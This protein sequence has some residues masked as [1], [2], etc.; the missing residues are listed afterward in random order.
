M[1]ARV[2]TKAIKIAEKIVSENGNFL[3][4]FLLDDGR[5]ILFW[6]T[7]A[8]ERL[9]SEWETA[10]QKMLQQNFWFAVARKWVNKTTQEYLPVV[11]LEKNE[12]KLAMNIAIKMLD[13]NLC[14]YVKPKKKKAGYV[15]LDS[16]TAL[17]GLA[18]FAEVATA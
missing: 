1:A 3:I 12:L 5:H 2:T 17:A 18:K 7:P 16:L 13:V 10:H 15:V 8:G 9:I 11:K 4:H 14:V 6:M